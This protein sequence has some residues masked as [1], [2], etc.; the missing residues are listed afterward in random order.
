MKIINDA[1]DQVR[2]E[3]QVVIGLLKATRYIWLKNPGKLTEKQ[4]KKLEDWQ[5]LYIKTT[6]TYQLKLAFQELF[7]QA[8]SEAHFFLQK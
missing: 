4:K 2:R 8:P 6:R 7:E 3:E 1:V 5:Q